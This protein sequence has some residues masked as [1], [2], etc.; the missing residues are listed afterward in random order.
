[1]TATLGY[2]A[3]VTRFAP[4]KILCVGRNY[5]AH[6][7]ELGNEVPAEPLFF[8]KPPSSLLEPGGVVLLPPES[9]RVDF[10]GELAV[11]IGKR[12][13][14]VPRDHALDHV[15]GYTI[16]CDVTARDLQKRDGQWTRGKGFDTFCPV[17]PEVVSGVDPS[18]LTLE[19]FVNDE[20]RQHARTSEMVFD[21]ADLVARASAFMTLEPGDLLLTG[22]P[23][24]VGPLAPGDRVRVTISGLGELRFTVAQEM[25]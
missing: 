1:M 15:Q 20:R 25:H 12:A 18:A 17:G 21:V 9:E 4:S 7:A 14:R 13:R 5:R 23:E 16:A 11:V 3:P 2:T 24:G 6:A 8:L 10:E 22:T 19:L